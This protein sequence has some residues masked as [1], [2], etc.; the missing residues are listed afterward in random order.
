MSMIIII[1][2]IGHILGMALP[3]CIKSGYTVCG[4]LIRF[5]I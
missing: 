5:V 1:N 2:S 3:F 4:K